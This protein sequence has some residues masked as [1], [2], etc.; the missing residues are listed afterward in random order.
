MSDPSGKTDRTSTRSIEHNIIEQVYDRTV[1]RLKEA[2]MGA[3]PAEAEPRQAPI[4]LKATTVRPRQAGPLP[5]QAGQRPRVAG[6][7]G[8]PAGVR[9]CSAVL[10]AIPPAAAPPVPQARPSLPGEDSPHLRLTRRGRLVLAVCAAAVLGLFCFAAVSGAR[11]AGRSAPPGA[12]GHSLSRIAVQP[13]QTLWSI[14]V[15]ADP[16]ADPRLV[17]QR[18]V[19]LNRLPGDSV[20]AGQRLLVPSG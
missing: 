2:E 10:R 15:Q 12:A 5:R 20:E 16:Q 1:I 17:V 4:A 8:H 19:T 9:A 18:I 11:A 14:A 13:G 6:P 7:R 3:M